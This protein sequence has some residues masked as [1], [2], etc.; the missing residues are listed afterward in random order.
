[1]GLKTCLITFYLQ[2]VRSELQRG[3]RKDKKWII[4]SN[5]LLKIQHVFLV[6][7]L[8]RPE[9]L[10]QQMHYCIDRAYKSTHCSLLYFMYTRET[11]QSFPSLIE[12]TI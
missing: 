7:S 4:R 9:F 3:V 6:R 1:M 10:R 2:A 11:G 8:S 5:S 12:S